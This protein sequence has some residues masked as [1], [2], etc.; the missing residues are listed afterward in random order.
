[1]ALKGK[2][3]LYEKKY[4]E[5]AG[6]AKRVIESGRFT[7][8]ENYSDIF[9]KKIL[10][11]KEV[12]FQTPY[13]DKNDRNN[14]A[15]IFR[16]YY[17]P[18]PYYADLLVGDNRDTSALVRNT[19]GS[20]RNK[21]FNNT[22]FNGQSLTADTDY[23]LRLDEIYLI[24]AEATARSGGSRDDAK[25]A[26][27]LIRARVQMPDITASAKDELLEA[28][29]VEKIL[30]LGAEDGEEW[31]DLVRYAVEGDI[32]IK[33]FKP[34]VISETKYVLPL[35]KPTVDLSNGVVEQNPGY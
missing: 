13:D 27:N 18:S 33:S 7:L 10:N 16:A 25:A 35:P 34:G 20:L 12:I 5:S 32:D 3:L 24:L 26:L 21:K 31:Y 6:F 17:L 11:T 1:M 9:T 8:E 22:V 30:E 23:F 29:R 14:K 15:F 4:A 28:I 2:V 19:N